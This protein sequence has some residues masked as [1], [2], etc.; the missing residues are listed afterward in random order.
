MTSTAAKT[1]PLKPAIKPRLR[2]VSH[3]FA[4]YGSALAGYWLVSNTQYQTSDTITAVTVYVLCLFLMFMSSALYHRPTW[5]VRSRAI[6]RR[7]DHC[8]IYLL[9]AGTSTPVAVLCLPPDSARTM[10]I[11]LWTGA[12]LG[13]VKS[14]FWVH[15]PKPI[16]ALAYVLL[17][18]SAA[19]FFVQ[20][21]PALGPHGLLLILGGGVLYIVGA[22]A[23]A[24]KR[25]NPVPG[26][27]G[28]HEI[29]H[30]LVIAAAICHFTAI[31]NLI[32]V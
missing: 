8:A 19:P 9:I 24:L 13:I 16:T 14:L 1:G 5:S 32:G 28:Y 17:G 29:F 21:G 25:P 15:A 2:G 23:Y 22:V 11:V 7:V 6:L 3:E 26:V 10:L 20:F 12:A 31:R 30:A 27:F 18:L 4:A